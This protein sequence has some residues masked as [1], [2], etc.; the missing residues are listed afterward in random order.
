M[1]CPYCGKQ[2]KAPRKGMERVMQHCDGGLL[3]KHDRIVYGV[4][5]NIFLTLNKNI[6]Q[7]L[8]NRGY[9]VRFDSEQNEYEI[10]EKVTGEVSEMAQE[11]Q[12]NFDLGWAAWSTGDREKAIEIWKENVDKFPNHR[13]SWYN[14]GLAYGRKKEFKQGIHC[15]KR[16]LEIDTTDGQAWW[17]LGFNYNLMGEKE[18]SKQAFKKAKKLGWK[19]P[20]PF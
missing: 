1:K 10:T 17:Y 18:K 6:A 2:M 13:D 11:A 5:H 20:P 9:N 3:K 16:A 12:D 14:L 15:L 4:P 19:Q 8:G 7:E